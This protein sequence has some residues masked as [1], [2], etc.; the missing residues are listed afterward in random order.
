MANELLIALAGDNDNMFTNSLSW[1][2][3]M[4]SAIQNSFSLISKVLTFGRFILAAL[5]FRATNMWTIARIPMIDATFP[6]INM[7]DHCHT[8][9][10]YSTLNK[11][12]TQKLSEKCR[13]EGVTVTAAISSAI[14]CATSTLV[15]SDEDRP[16][17]LHFSIGADTRRRCV[18]PVPNHDLSYHVSGVMSFV[19]PT[20]DIPTTSEGV[21]QLAKTFGQHIKTCIDASQILASGMIMGKIFQ[22]TLGPP[23][24]ADLP[25][26]GISSWGILPF[27]EQYGP[28]KLVA[29]TPF[30]N[31]IRAL[32]PFTIIQTV[33]GI[34]TIAY[35]GAGPIIQ[36]SI[37]E[38]L[39]DGTIQKL[40]QMLED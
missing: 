27:S 18:P 36:L 8:E 38:K 3:T 22:K 30:V 33:N 21:W 16:T 34:L 26:C 23:T 37:L 10:C 1:P 32:L 14:L 35:V 19:T 12:E 15:N 7:A 24:F 20:R 31:I 5:Y 25:T 11:E 2:V 17:A 29:M 4:E 28:W 9:A 6:L 39:R 40:Y 13:R